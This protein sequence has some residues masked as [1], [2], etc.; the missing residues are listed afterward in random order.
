MPA[1]R[2]LSVSQGGSG[3]TSPAF[4]VSGP[5]SPT[6]DHSERLLTQ[7]HCH[8]TQSDG[9]F[10]P[11]EVVDSYLAKGYDVLAITDHDMVTTQPAGIATSISANELSPSQQHIISLNSDYTRGVTTDAQTIIDAIVADGGQAQV[12][13]PNW[14]IGMTSGE[15]AA[16]TDYLGFEIHNGTV[17]P[18]AGGQSPITF[19]GYAVALWDT[20]LASNKSRWGFS[21]DDW[22]FV[23][24]YR[25]N[26]VGR[27]QVF[28]A[29]PSVA[30]VMGAL[31][32]GNFAADV[33][34]YGVTP[35]YPNRG[36]LGV[37][38]S[39]P[40]AVRI[41]AY[42]TG[43]TLLAT[44][45]GTSIAYGFDGAEEYVRLVAVG[46]YTEPFDA[47]SDRWEDVDG[48]W[49]VAGGL[50]SLS[51]DI[52]QRRRILRRHREGDFAAQVDVRIQTNGD[53]ASVALVFNVLDDD[54][55]YMLRLGE[56]TGLPDYDDKLTV[57]VTQNNSFAAV[58][59][60]GSHSIAA[61][62]NTWY[63]VKMAYTASSGRV[64]AKVWVVGDTEPDWQIDGTDT[65]WKHGAFGFRANRTPDFDNLYISGFRTYY[66]PIAID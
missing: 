35:G 5:Y 63:T 19:G 61:S 59:P 23:D 46:D 24:A 45:T 65:T 51:S 6:A 41:E 4:V 47:D 55:Y 12:A 9:N 57:A 25:V 28:A 64:Q 20:V 18:G 3:F 44:S 54:R 37:S 66:Q 15:L 2:L 36:N 34:N 60:F 53:D 62:D 43:G 13:H 26:D 38:L 40:G 48:S 52:T 56:A 58:T 31:V 42:G 17:V 39:C 22:H 21:V 33:S 27:L 29:S 10:T 7:I 30:D 8:T 32:A 50:L 14:S 11:A 16:L 1:R 49:T